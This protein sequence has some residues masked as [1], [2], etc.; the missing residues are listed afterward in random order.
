M[1]SNILSTASKPRLEDRGN[2]H[3]SASKD[4]KTSKT[5]NG[6]NT[7]KESRTVTSLSAAIPGSSKKCKRLS[8]FPMVALRVGENPSLQLSWIEKLGNGV[9][10]SN[11]HDEELN[12]DATQHDRP[13]TLISQQ[14]A[15]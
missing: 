5:G 8:P 3:A 6:S 12:G 2:L 14:Q 11:G 1:S 15:M 4:S 13:E 10:L 9:A 7:K